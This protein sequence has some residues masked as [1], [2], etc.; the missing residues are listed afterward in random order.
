MAAGIG[1]VAVT[2]GVK[3]IGDSHVITGH[4]IRVTGNQKGMAGTG[5][6]DIGNKSQ[7]KN[8]NLQ[9]CFSEISS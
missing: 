6:V 2:Y 4:G 9:I 1:E 3:A 5:D 8:V 7:L